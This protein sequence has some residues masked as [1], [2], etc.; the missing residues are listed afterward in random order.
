MPDTAPGLVVTCE[1]ASNRV[2]SRAKRWFASAVAREALASHRGYDPGAAE[3]AR[4]FAREFS[5]PAC[6]GEFTRLLIELNRSL[7]HRQLWSEFTRDL[8]AEERRHWIDHVYR[9]YRDAART[10]LRRAIQD[11]GRVVHLGVHSFT[12]ESNGEIRNVD[13]GL[14]YDPGRDGERTFCLRWR[15]LLRTAA[16]DLRVRR[17]QPYRGVAD[18]FITELRNEFTDREYVGIE[19]EVNQALVQTDKATWRRLQTLLIETFAEVVPAEIGVGGW[20]R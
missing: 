13:V 8:D 4:R 7:H 19:I 20:D 9:P 6:F 17:N 11:C 12:P 18:G 5:A 1:H 10:H 16:P 2:P 15:D 14:L 3:L